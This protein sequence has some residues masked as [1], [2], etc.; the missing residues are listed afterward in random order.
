MDSDIYMGLLHVDFGKYVVRLHGLSILH[1]FMDTKKEQ[2]R[3]G[4]LIIWQ[5][6]V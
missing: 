1:G 2:N 5:E 4:D 3:Y 6:V